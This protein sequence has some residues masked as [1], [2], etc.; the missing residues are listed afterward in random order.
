MD[1][2]GKPRE[3][4]EDGPTPD[5]EILGATTF[6]NLLA[7]NENI[8]T[9]APQIGECSGLPGATK[10]VTTLEGASEMETINPKCGTSEQGAAAVVEAE[11]EPHIAILEWLLPA[12][13]VTIGDCLTSGVWLIPGQCAW[14]ASP[15]FSLAIIFPNPKS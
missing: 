9:F 6:D 10:E 14:S 2:D 4:G 7:G 15:W 1:A 11:E 12:H 13:S 5:I 3:S 8:G